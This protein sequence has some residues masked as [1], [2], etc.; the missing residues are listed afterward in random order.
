[1]QKHQHPGSAEEH[2]RRLFRI[3]TRQGGLD[4]NVSGKS[5]QE[6]VLASMMDFGLRPWVADTFSGIDGADSVALMERAYESDRL[7]CEQSSYRGIVVPQLAADGIYTKCGSDSVA[8]RDLAAVVEHGRVRGL[9]VRP[10]SIHIELKYQDSVGST[11]DKAKGL[12]TEMLSGGA[13]YCM[14]LYG[15]IGA[16]PGMHDFLH[17][18]GEISDSILRTVNDYEVRPGGDPCTGKF[19]YA[20][21][22]EELVHQL[23]AICEAEADGRV[24]DY[25]EWRVSW[26]YVNPSD[27]KTANR[28]KK[29]RRVR[30]EAAQ[31]TI[32]TALEHVGSAA[33]QLGFEFR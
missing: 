31:Q 10:L 29:E 7:L 3:A 23:N 22:V 21:T 19:F 27:T 4:A 5:F 16:V 20:S 13:D 33:A 1:M 9:A 24:L 17:R 12:P 28:H 14:V 8:R 25:S 6:D 11:D 30:K 26:P 32:A 2:T 18:S 15:G